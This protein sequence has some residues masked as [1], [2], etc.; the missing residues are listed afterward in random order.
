MLKTDLIKSDCPIL[1]REAKN[2]PLVYLDNAAT[3]QKPRQVIE[4][5]AD[6]YANHNA[7]VHRGL[8]TL[9][10][11]A[12][13]MYEDARRVVAG[14]IGATDLSEVIFTT[15]TTESLNRVAFTWAL[16]N[17]QEG[18]S[19]LLTDIEHHSNLI[20]W[21]IVAKQTG[22]KLEY[23]EIGSD[24]TGNIILEKFKDKL[25]SL[26]G[27]VKLVCF[28][29]A[30][31]VLGTILPVKEISK[32]AHAV[33]ALV[34]IDG[35][36]AV[37]HIPVNVQSLDCDF[38]AFSGHK[39]L[40][41]TGIGVLWARK[42]LLESMEPFI[43]GGGMIDVVTLNDS[44]WAVLP[45][46][47]EAGT[48]H[49]AGAIGLSRAVK[50]LRNLDMK[51]IREHEVIMN[52]YAL[53]KLSTIE[54]LKILGPADAQE[55]TGLIAFSVDGIHSHDLAAVLDTVGVAVRSGHHCCMPL[56]KKLNISSSTRASFYI[57]NNT[58]D[59]DRLV[60][61]IQKAIKILGKNKLKNLEY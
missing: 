13:E 49:I 8:H 9:S 50:Y 54:G 41:P 55:R 24:D 28:S 32:A 43:Y 58:D 6:Y 7:N 45:E 26:S 4:A 57:Y 42:N 31:N 34:C 60:E 14:F 52:T 18:D 17:L 61:G 53:N 36:Q 19:I 40:G 10:E 46:K 48:P 33:G 15:G 21:Q 51:N 29:Q 20:P 11:E 3:S 39:M 1:K 35:A 37:P 5:I 38:Y 30:S 12:T 59:I 27:K 23:I 16:F 2:H 44:T 25:S 22:A 56:H 47:L